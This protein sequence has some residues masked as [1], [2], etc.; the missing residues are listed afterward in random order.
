[1]YEVLLQL[2]SKKS[3]KK[4]RNKEGVD[5]EVPVVVVPVAIAEVVVLV[6]LSLA[7]RT[8]LA[9]VVVALLPDLLL[10]KEKRDIV[11]VDR[12]QLKLG[13]VGVEV[14]LAELK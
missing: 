12:Q 1:M 7:L 8:V 14:T 13:V 10:L 11:G 5:Q 6:V 2:N 3:I 9:Q 4:K